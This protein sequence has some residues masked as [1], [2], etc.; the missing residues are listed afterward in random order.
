M[1]INFVLLTFHQAILM[2]KLYGLFLLHVIILTHFFRNAF[3]KHIQA[4]QEFQCTLI[5]EKQHKAVP[6]TASGS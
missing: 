3:F 6:E 2:F 5:S 4:F 1:V